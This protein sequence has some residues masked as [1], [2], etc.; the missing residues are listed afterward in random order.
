MLSK[1]VKFESFGVVILWTP[2]QRKRA[3][4]L[5]WASMLYYANVLFIYLFLWPPY[6]PVLVNGSSRK[7]K[8]VKLPIYWQVGLN[9][10][11]FV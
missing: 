4:M 3:Y 6:S 1:L 7:F 8:I 9:C 10:H 2:A 11:L 5:Y